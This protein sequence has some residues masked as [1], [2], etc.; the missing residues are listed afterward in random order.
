MHTLTRD[1]VDTTKKGKKAY[2]TNPWYVRAVHF[3]RFEERRRRGLPVVE[4]CTSH[5]SVLIDA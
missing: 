5:G 4:L 3:D 2:Q 1:Y